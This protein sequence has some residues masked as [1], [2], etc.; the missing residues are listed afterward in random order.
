[1][2]LENNSKLIMIGD[3]V[4]DCGRDYN[5]IASYGDGYVNLVNAFLT[6]L[7]PESKI[8]VINKGVNGNTILDLEERF[9]EDV[10]SLN[11]DYLTIMIGINDVWRQ[12]DAV[13]QP[14]TRYAS[15]EK[16]Y[17]TYTKLIKSVKDKVKQ[18]FI[19][20]PFMIIDTKDYPMRNMTERY[21]QI[22]KKVAEENGL[23]YIDVQKEF[24]KFTNHLSSYILSADHV[25]PNVQGHTIIAKAFLD[26][27]NFKF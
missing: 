17:D 26:S 23:I 16:F 3:S 12:F 25:H 18:I 14:N 10:L 24:D 11:P 4:T 15:E 9:E 21:A 20:S 2:I 8:S 13:L 5:W 1:M 22:C 7:S 27:I 6:A 19:F